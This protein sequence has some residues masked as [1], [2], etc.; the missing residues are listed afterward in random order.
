MVKQGKQVDRRFDDALVDALAEMCAARIAPMPEWV[1]FIPSERHPELVPSLARRL[2]ERLGLPVRE[3][4]AKARPTQPQKG[5]QNSANQFRNIWG[6]LSVDSSLD[7]SCLL[8]DDVIDS[9]WT[10]TVAARE[11]RRAGCSRVV[12]IALASAGQ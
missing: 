12:P 6:S 10:V 2:G 7:G 1:T 3:V 4:I 9:R 11:L 5:M 8:V